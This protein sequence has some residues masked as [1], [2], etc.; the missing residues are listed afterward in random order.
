MSIL[1]GTASWTDKCLIGCGRFYPKKASSSEA[2]LRH[3]ATQ[4]PMVEVDSR[5]YAMPGATNA[6]LWLERTP[7][8]LVFNV[9]AFRLFTGH[10]TSPT[11]L[12]KDIQIA[13]AAVPTLS[14]KKLFYYRELPEDIRGELWQRF[15]GASTAVCNSTVANPCTIRICIGMWPHS[16]R[17]RG[18]RHRMRFGYTSY[19]QAP[20]RG[21]CLSSTPV[22]HSVSG[23]PG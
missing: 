3:Y 10:E 17:G 13:L 12:P 22:R 7:A 14:A 5:Y 20:L 15:L 2:R 1:V 4:F 18:R 9:K 21:A 11:V 16:C 6:Q 23:A 19:R 8:D